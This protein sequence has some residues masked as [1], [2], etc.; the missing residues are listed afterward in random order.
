MNQSFRVLAAALLGWTGSLAFIIPTAHAAPETAVVTGNRANLRSEPSAGSDIVGTVV[1]GQSLVVLEQIP[2]REPQAED[3]ASW[4]K[5]RLPASVKVWVFAAFVDP[6]SGTV[7]SREVKIRSGAGKNY[8]AVGELDKGDLVVPI[9]TVDGWMQIEPPGHAVGYVAGNL[10]QLTG[11]PAATHAGAGKPAMP[12]VTGPQKSV[13]QPDRALAGQPVEPG[14]LAPIPEAPRAER[15]PRNPPAGTPLVTPEP[16]V[17]APPSIPV[18]PPPTL[19]IRPEPVAVL[20]PKA[21]QPAPDTNAA[22]VEISTSVQ[23][24]QPFLTYDENRP[25]RVLREGVIGLSMSPDA[26]SWYQLDSFRRGESLID[27]LIV[28]DPKKTDLSK[29]RGKRVFIEG[30]EYRDRRWRTPVLKI[31]SVRAAI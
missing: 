20:T 1:K 26:P 22:P 17:D 5:V 19:P 30:D 14:N 18:T 3:P 9:R 6:K 15:L 10:L 27:Y 31:I 13:G 16:A 23:Y 28:D 21:N 29:W 2:V 12:R 24:R 25:R 11:K 7:T 8:A 4:A